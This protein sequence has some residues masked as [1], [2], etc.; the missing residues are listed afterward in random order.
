MGA[1]AGVSR[2]TLSSARLGDWGGGRSVFAADD[3]ATLGTQ[4]SVRLQS[5]DPAHIGTLRFNTCKTD[6]VQYE[7]LEWSL[8]NV[9]ERCQVDA[10]QCAF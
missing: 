7:A 1:A 2:E 6:D 8:A 9:G 10:R 4:P 5:W 3:A